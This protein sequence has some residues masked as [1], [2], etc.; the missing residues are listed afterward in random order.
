[1]SEEK[2]SVPPIYFNHLYIV[3]DDKTY[4]AIQD[5]AFLQTAFPGFE[6]R[7][8]L[9]ASGESWAGSYF[10]CQDN[11]LELF[12]ESAGRHWH[13]GAQAGWAGIAFSS[14]QPGGVRAVRDALN[15]AFHHEPFNELRQVRTGD[16]TINWFYH[17]KLADRLGLG[18]FDSW[19]MEYHPDIFKQKGIPLPSGGRLTRQAYLSPWNQER[20]VDPLPPSAPQSAPPSGESDPDGDRP[21]GSA[22]VSGAPVFTRI[23]GATIHLDERRA[24][25]YAE[26]LTLLG[27]QRSGSAGALDLS[28]HGFTLQIR[29]ESGAPAGYRL[30][31]LRLAMARPSVA[32]MTFVF[33]AGSRLDLRE[34]LSAEW[35]FGVQN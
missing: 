2:N 24:E 6:R 11:Y 28:A 8:T 5:S 13:P 16:K 22:S 26:I 18:S 29:P 23:T 34:D 25:R 31:S 10:Y 17:V 27:Y 32:P 35:C 19:V 14:D 12:G 4:R 21:A 3:L 30:S 7:A 33:A 20:A 15:A 9:T 1:M